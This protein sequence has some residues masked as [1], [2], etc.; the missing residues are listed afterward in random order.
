MTSKIIVN[1]IEADTG[2]S[3]VTFASN[4]NLQNDSSVLVSSSGVTLGTGSTIAAPSANEITLSTNSAER[5]R[6]T[7]DGNVGIN[8]TPTNYSNYVTLALSDTTGSTIEGRVSGTLKGSLTFDSQVTLNAVTSIPL[9]LKTANTERLRITSTGIVQLATDAVDFA[10]GTGY[11]TAK[12]SGDLIF[13]TTNSYTE[14]LRIKSDGKIGFNAANPP[15]DYCFHSGQADTNI[16]ITNNTTGIDDSAG[17]LIQQDGNDLY[18]WNKENSFMS[19]GTNAAERVRITSDGKVGINRTNPTAPITARRTDAGGT[20]TSG[21]IAEFANSSGYGV[22]FG[23]SSASGASWGATTG[24]F[25]WNTGGLSSQVERLRIDSS[26]RTLIGSPN[27]ST[28]QL[29]QIKGDTGGSANGGT[30]L[31]QNGVA[32]SSAANGTGLGGIAFGGATG[33]QYCRIEGFADGSGG[34]NDYPGRLSFSTTADGA[35]SPSERMRIDASGYV[36]K[37][38]TPAF[39]VYRNQSIWNLA[40]GDTFV[41]NTAE[42]N[43]GNHYNTSNGR[44]TAPITARYVFHFWSIYT[45]DANS[46]YIQMYKNGA[47]MY[48]GDV[49]FTNS[50]GSAWDSVHYSRVIQLSSG[51]YVYMRSG[52]AHTYH[53]NH[54]GG[55]SGYMLG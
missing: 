37:P 18:I 28:S 34:T 10:N 19:L 26:G 31:L 22:W 21:V 53:G 20:G 38:N 29:L 16:Q 46:D 1:T 23:Q 15:R 36:T 45:G 49:H 33:N 41:F 44:F 32:D 13:R 39:F 30:I 50:I 35:S 54:W 52:S 4:I 40:A 12:G 3:S 24:D 11:I 42:L 17:A 2:I 14:R 8:V 27:G 6:I 51:D 7:S 48:G 25:Y 43:V 5:L 9:V 47:R 55:W